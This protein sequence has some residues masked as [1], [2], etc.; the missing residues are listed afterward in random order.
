MFKK[1]K[2]FSRLIVTAGI[3]G[4]TLGAAQMASA[5]QSIT[6]DTNSSIRSQA[7]HVATGGLYGL[8]NSTTPNASLLEPL[9]PKT[10]TQPPVNAGQLPNGLTVPGGQFDKVAPTAK[11]IGAKIIVRLPDIYPQFPY[12]FS[13]EKDWLQRVQTMVTAVKNSGYADQV[14]GF[15][16]WNEPSGYWPDPSQKVNQGNYVN[17]TYDDLW[18]QSYAEI[19]QILPDAKIVGPSLAG[20]NTTWMQKFFENAQKNNTMPDY[21]SW[22]QWDPASYVD[23]VNQLHQLEDSMGIKHFPISINEYAWKQELGVPGYMI[24]YMQNFEN[25]TDTDSAD[26]AFW[27]NYGRMDNLLT[28]QQKPNGGYWFFKWYGDMSGQMDKT[29]TFAANKSLASLANTNSNGTSVIF[30]GASGSVNVHIAGLKLGKTASVQ[31]NETPWYGVDTAVTPKKV[32]TGLVPVKNGKISVP[33]KH[34]AFTTGYQI[35]VKSSKKNVKKAVYKYTKAS[36]KNPLRAEAEFGK[37]SKSNLTVQQSSYASAG[38]FVRGF[39]AQ[40]A[41]DSMSV[42]ALKAGKYQL[43][44]GYA[45]NND[46]SVIHL[47]L[48][49]KSLGTASLPNTTG[50]MDA[51]PNVHGT[52]KVVQL[53]TVH[54]KKGT[55][56]LTVS[57]ATNSIDLDYVQFTLIK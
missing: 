40:G 32:A 39:T 43:E 29:S 12:N 27:F 37:F 38:E 11:A 48:N 22:H 49:N 15:E 21:I 57:N 36:S 14:Y 2:L 10:F 44:L 1:S 5:D 35:V 3:F 47:A 18:N 45:N 26:L 13:N 56:T 42:K 17:V 9:H 34:T 23:D 50:L 28:D 52:R 41:A 30:G 6:V 16:I 4:L 54:L 31:I 53:K 46:T 7:S 8:Q 20:W 33:V 51:V 55:N 24:H 19:K 25:V